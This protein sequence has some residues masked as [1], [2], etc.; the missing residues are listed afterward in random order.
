VLLQAGATVC[1][2]ACVRACELTYTPF[3]QVDAPTLAGWT[4][5]FAA[6]DRGHTEVAE[7][8]VTRVRALCSDVCACVLMRA[9]AQYHAN[10][11]QVSVEGT[12]PL[13]HAA[14]HGKTDLCR[15]LIEKVT[16]ARAR[17]CVCERAQVS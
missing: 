11:N 13:Y 12:V 8:L 7:E 16:R 1:V 4:P 14:C 2:R 3:A 5:L 9:R 10:V 15:F 6:A 17:V